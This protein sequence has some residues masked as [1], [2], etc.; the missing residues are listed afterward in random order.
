MSHYTRFK[1]YTGF[2]SGQVIYPKIQINPKISMD[3][4]GSCWIGSEFNKSIFDPKNE[5]GP[6]LKPDFG[7]TGL[8]NG[9][10]SGLIRSGWITNQPNPFAALDNNKGMQC[11]KNK[12]DGDVPTSRKTRV[13]LWIQDS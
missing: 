7:S 11:Q 9:F 6:I 8:L 12:R 2:E 4:V 13:E 5:T 10:G 1:S 3:R